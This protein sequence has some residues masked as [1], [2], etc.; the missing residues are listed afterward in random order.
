MYTTSFPVV[1][2]FLIHL[3]LI[4]KAAPTTYNDTN[5]DARRNPSSVIG[6]SAPACDEPQLPEEANPNPC[7]NLLN[8]LNA[9]YQGQGLISWGA[10][11][12]AQF[13]DFPWY[14]RRLHC[15]IAVE[16]TDADPT[17]V[18]VRYDAIHLLPLLWQIF[19]I[20]LIAGTRENPYARGNVTFHARESDVELRLTLREV[21]WHLPPEDSGVVD[22]GNATVV[23]VGGVA[24]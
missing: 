20:C 15:E 2:T 16:P 3:I 8:Q 5:A 23:H 24:R 7:S 21:H 22:A 13:R 10:D 11:A 12:Y 17:T 19:T 4:N 18:N 6:L 9:E 14:F 1:F